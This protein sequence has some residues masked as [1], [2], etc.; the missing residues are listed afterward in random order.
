MA[1]SSRNKLIVRVKHG[2]FLLG[3]FSFFAKIFSFSSLYR[4]IKKMK[5][6]QQPNR[7]TKWTLRDLY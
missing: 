6:F 5:H 2:N 1:F 7:E 4:S 3:S